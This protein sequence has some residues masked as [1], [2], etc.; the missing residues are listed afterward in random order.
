[1]PGVFH[2][3][4]KSFPHH[5]KIGPVF[6]RHGTLSGSFSMPWKKVFHT[7]EKAV[8]GSGR[9]EPGGRKGWTAAR[10]ASG[11]RAAWESWPTLSKATNVLR[12]AGV[13]AK[14]RRVWATRAR[15]SSVPMEI[16]GGTGE[17]AGVGDRLVCKTVEAERPSAPEGQEVQRGESGQLCR[18]A[19]RAG[20][21]ATCAG[22]GPGIRTRGGGRRRG[23][24]C[25]CRSCARSP[26]SRTSR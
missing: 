2:G 17:G 5:G 19:G 22:A 25:R 16:E 11:W 6:P 7:M 4:E 1:V 3:V 18:P 9:R 12:R 8:E 10:Q 26:R 15:G 21:Q 13:A 24:P 23:R 20:R 14:T